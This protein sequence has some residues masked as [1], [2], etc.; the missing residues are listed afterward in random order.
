M[1]DHSIK[2]L[3]SRNSSVGS[4]KE[5]IKSKQN[6]NKKFGHRPRTISEQRK[7]LQEKKLLNDIIIR[8]KQ[9]L[10]TTTNTTRDNTLT[11]ESS[12]K[13]NY[14]DKFVNI[15]II[16]R[17]SDFSV[18]QINNKINIEKIEDTEFINT[19]IYSMYNN[20]QNINRKTST[21]SED[22][23][24][25][26]YIFP[27]ENKISFNILRKYII[28]IEKNFQNEA[29][30]I[31]SKNQSGENILLNSC[32]LKKLENL[33]S[34]FGLIIFLLIKRKK[35]EMAK[36]VFLLLLKENKGYIDYI[37]KNIIEW[38]SISI[39]R[40]NI[41]K[42]YPKSLYELIRIYSFI[43]KYSQF[44]NMMYYCSIFVGRYFD[45]IY[46]I[47][48]YFIY[49]S[50][51]RGFTLDTKSQL[52][53]WFSLSLHNA[54]YFFLSNY[55]PLN[56]SMNYINHI[57]NLYNNSNENYL[58]NKENSLLIKSFYNLGLIHFLN[59]QDDRAVA[60]LNEA[61]DMI[62]N[63]EGSDIFELDNNQPNL[64]NKKSIFRQNSNKN[65]NTRETIRLSTP[66]NC[67]ENINFNQYKN[68][69]INKKNS[70]KK[71]N[72]V[73]LK[74]KIDLE[75]INLLINYGKQSGIMNENN[76][77]YFD[78]TRISLRS[79]SPRYKFKY[80]PIPNYFKNPLLR[81]TEFLLGEIEIDRKN[82]NSAYDHIL[83]AFYI[84][85]SLKLT[86]KN[87]EYI[88][89]SNEQKIIHKY[90]EL[91]YKLSEKETKYNKKM[92]TELNLAMQLSNK[93]LKNNNMNESFQD[94]NLKEES[95]NKI[96]D[97][98]KYNIFNTD[99]NEKEKQKK[100]ILIC[101]QKDQDYKI[102]KELEKFFIFLCSLSFYQL[103]IL[104]ETQP[105]NN[106]RDD[107]P[108]LFSSQ[109]KDCLTN[110][111]RNELDNLQTMA[112]SRFIIL[113]NTNKWILP[114]NLNIGIVDE[115]KMRS[116]LRKNATKFINKYCESCK[117]NDISI[118]QT[119]E[120]K[121]F[122]DILKSNK[123]N[124]EIK[125]Y[126]NKNFDLVIKLL[127]KISDEEVENILNSPKI[128]IESINKYK[129]RKLKK[130]EKL[131][132][133]DNNEHFRFNHKN[134]YDYDDNY[135]SNKIRSRALSTSNNL[136]K[137]N[138]LNTNHE[139]RE[140]INNEFIKKFF[141]KNQKRNLS[142]QINN[143]IKFNK[144][145]KD[146]NDSYQDIQL[147]LEGSDDIK[148]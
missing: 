133:K 144:K 40:I 113:K 44:F 129:K 33:V 88:I 50:S 102:V 121:I 52:N 136:K 89:Y 107:L 92:K 78:T 96:L 90:L 61:K 116:Y 128:I 22:T 11:S 28:K 7:Q 112:L 1:D 87:N 68:D 117:N 9:K 115:Q 99:I 142:V 2:N 49:K 10:L 31:I 36:N 51:I 127:K 34:R 83:R 148:E 57:I 13:S 45:I 140:C 143:G 17:H 72:E 104:N 46:Y 125:E 108:I 131:K 94:D 21:N 20:N 73:F 8:K 132:N 30:D 37:E 81:K 105:D 97:K 12:K 122:Q 67:S 120:F 109:F 69:E 23:E 80:L 42:E 134:N 135:N 39:K 119:R 54:S 32:F 60:N 38:Y 53:F 62:M 74:D 84:I 137:I 77:D 16:S 3:K 24:N 86:Q 55:F 101:G 114:V 91:I 118:R 79:K 18:E 59:G 130:L 47:Y 14:Y 146:Y 27:T 93:S 110:F 35:I 56:L 64:N 85:I 100:E 43:I 70:I 71:M 111:Q 98:Y 95:N 141:Q 4:Y 19:L 29:N 66:M 75:D 6:N 15:N 124:N 82:Y 5:K 26:N 123:S 41:A 58:T 145:E 126:I 106:K 147:S 65:D 25:E 48:N 63:S 76:C 138:K 103:K 139:Y